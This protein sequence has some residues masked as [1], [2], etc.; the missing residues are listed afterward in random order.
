MSQLTLK[1]KAA[2][3]GRIDLSG[4][5]PAVAVGAS[6]AAIAQ[7]PVGNGVRLGDVFT[8]SGTT[9]GAVT[10]VG[11]SDRI[12]GIGAGLASGTLVVDGD[13]GANAGAGMRGGM[14][15]IHGSTGP[16]LATGMKAGIV[17][18]TGNAG[19]Y[20]G[21][22]AAG[23]RFGITGGSVI[24][25]GSIGARAGDKMRRGLILV[26]GTT[27]DACG[28]RMIGGTIV[29][30]GGFGPNAGQLMRR[31]TLIG[32]KAERLPSTFADCGL[33][34]LVILS[35]MSRAWTR[36]LGALAPKPLPGTVR[37]FAGDLATIGKGE[38]LITAQ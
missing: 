17:H 24:I 2:P 19:D 35:V 6:A 34:E 10:L 8:V 11:S 15:E 5:A 31:G 12:D 14:L 1:L 25:D 9:G 30:E 18:V 28:S 38:V 36:E 29:A 26:R 37:R 4:L 27:G 3:S 20:I 22:V 23:H 32:P 13:A 21:G 16:Y 7:L 33:H